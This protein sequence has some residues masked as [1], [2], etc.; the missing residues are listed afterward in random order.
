M[1]S[2]VLDT[3]WAADKQVLLREQRNVSIALA[4]LPGGWKG[5]TEKKGGKVTHF[6]R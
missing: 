4:L 3:Q 1:L 5:N 6:G 2:T